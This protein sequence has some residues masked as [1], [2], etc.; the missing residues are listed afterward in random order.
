MHLCP[1]MCVGAYL[2]M[3]SHVCLCAC[4]CAKTTY[5]S[6]L[7]DPVELGARYNLLGLSKKMHCT[8]V[9]YLRY[10]YICAHVPTHACRCLF[11][12]ALM[13]LCACMCAKTSYQS[14]V[15]NLAEVG[16]GYNLFKLSHEVHCSCVGI[17]EICT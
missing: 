6:S 8:C 14:P 2:C 17:F 16:A 7:P 12:H 13:C 10:M 5:Q 4:I 15:P 1:R 11:M 3:R 9:G